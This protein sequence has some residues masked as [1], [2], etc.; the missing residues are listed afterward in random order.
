MCLVRECE[1]FPA[2]VFLG[3]ADPPLLRM[4]P[5]RCRTSVLHKLRLLEVR[6]HHLEHLLP[7][8][9]HK[10]P[11]LEVARGSPSEGLADAAQ[12]VT[13]HRLL[14]GYRVG[15][16]ARGFR[17]PLQP[18]DELA[19]AEEATFRLEVCTDQCLRYVCQILVRC[20]EC[21]QGLPLTAPN[22]RNVPKPDVPV[23]HGK[24]DQVCWER[25]TEE[26]G[27]SFTR[28]DVS[29]CLHKLAI[30]AAWQARV[31]CDSQD[32]RQDL[33]TKATI[34]LEGCPSQAGTRWTQRC[35]QGQGAECRENRCILQGCQSQVL[36]DVPP[37]KNR[38]KPE[39]KF[40]GWRLPFLPVC[41]PEHIDGGACSRVF[42]WLSAVAP[43]C[44]PV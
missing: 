18:L 41:I 20:T 37:M 39:R 33:A 27:Q 15:R 14:P 12:Q 19:H 40:V 10:L 5:L 8:L 25:N 13:V 17:E 35:F 29:H 36:Q 21:L 34:V 42:L 31:S 6:V 4:R 38:R 32:Q 44:L 11:K 23:H 1:I 22:S 24:L 28:Q 3:V 2:G 43:P 30:C 16:V 26:F 9:I 7:T